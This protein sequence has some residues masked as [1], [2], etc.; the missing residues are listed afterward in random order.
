M[1][2][3]FKAFGCYYLFLNFILIFHFSIIF[4]KT[5]TLGSGSED[6]IEVGSSGLT[7]FTSSSSNAVS[8]TFKCKFASTATATSAELGVK[9][10]VAVSGTAA[11]ATGI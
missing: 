9:R 2:L 11:E 7:L 8:V 6:G 4:T 3:V 1:L 5:I 10:R